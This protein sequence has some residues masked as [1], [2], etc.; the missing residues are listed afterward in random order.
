MHTQA[1]HWLQECQRQ[2]QSVTSEVGKLSGHCQ[3]L[4]ECQRWGAR[5]YCSPWPQR[6]AWLS[7]Q[8]PP[9]C[10]QWNSLP[11]PCW[12]PVQFDTTEGPTTWCQLPWESAWRPQASNFQQYFCIRL[13][14]LP[15]ADRLPKTIWISQTP[16]NTLLDASLPFRE[17]RSNFT[18]QNTGT[19]PSHQKTLTR[20]WS[21]PIHWGKTPQ[22]KVTTSLQS[23]ERKPQRQ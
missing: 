2:V 15:L 1:G 13:Q 20:Q 4:H 12:E 17:T 18:H 9:S 5:C 19:S 16:K 10:E 14:T 23:A 22:I 8:Q 11:T 7:L 21:N 3:S 6:W